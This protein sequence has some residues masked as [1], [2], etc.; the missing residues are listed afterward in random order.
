MEIRNTV[1][2][3]CKLII[4]EI[5][6]DFRGEYVETWNIEGYNILHIPSFKQDDF[7]ISRQ[8]VLRGLH[9]DPLTWKLV[10]CPMGELLLG[11]LDIREVSQTRGKWQLFPLND[12]NRWQV[13]IPPGCANGH[14]CL[15]EKCM[16]YYKQ[17]TLYE[18]QKQFSYHYTS[19]GITWPSGYDFKLSERDKNA[20]PFWI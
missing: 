20:P 7:S 19:S 6:H 10:Q 16:F 18:E 12:K 17:T 11:V 14:L 2:D 3:D 8:G 9:G 4:P 15:S 1:I 13:L 5:F